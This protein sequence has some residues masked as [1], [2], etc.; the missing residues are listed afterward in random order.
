MYPIADSWRHCWIAEISNCCVPESNNKSLYL[1]KKNIMHREC[2][3]LLVNKFEEARNL[4][5]IEVKLILYR[6]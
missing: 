2:I 6:I 5:C 4:P 3:L 1:R